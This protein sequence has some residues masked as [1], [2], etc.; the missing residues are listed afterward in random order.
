MPAWSWIAA[1]LVSNVAIIT[2]EYLNRT[3]PS[4][5]SAAK[6]T[7]LLIIMAQAGLYYTW[8]YAPHLMVAWAVFAVG[9]SLMRLL[10][11]S[12][13]LHAPMNFWVVTLGVLLM[14]GGSL[15]VKLGTTQ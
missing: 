6:H 10:M 3:Q 14:F 8:H 7:W 12:C 5:L 15:V 2:V 1:A 13:V 9:N 4:L 11:V